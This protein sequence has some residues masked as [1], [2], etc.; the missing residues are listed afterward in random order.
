MKS[1]SAFQK[2]QRPSS[3]KQMSNSLRA[4]SSINQAVLINNY[5]EKYLKVP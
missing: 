1:H 2:R 5:L 3:A 4:E